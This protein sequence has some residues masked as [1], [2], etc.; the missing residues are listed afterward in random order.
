MK[1]NSSGMVMPLALVLCSLFALLVL[2]MQHLNLQQPAL[3]QARLDTLRQREWAWVGLR[4]AL[5]DV[6]APRVDERHPTETAEAESLLFNSLP[7]T[8]AQ[9]RRWWSKALPQQCK[10]GICADLQDAHLRATWL[11]KTSGIPLK[12]ATWTQDELVYWIEPLLLNQGSDHAQLVF[13]ITVRSGPQV[14]QGWW[15]PTSPL[16]TPHAQG[17]WLSLMPLENA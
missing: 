15:R 16:S 8:E 14:W 5:M 2:S 1:P 4:A 6:H 10:E 12:L 13:R 7:A 11:N 9:W 17:E 3:I